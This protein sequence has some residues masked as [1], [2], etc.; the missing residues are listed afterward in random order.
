MS[1][2][3]I[4]MRGKACKPC[5]S[6]GDVME[7]KDT[8]CKWC[9]REWTIAWITFETKNGETKVIDIAEDAQEVNQNPK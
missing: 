6:A 1:S 9:G 2:T 5:M 8:V 4:T 7:P 3:K